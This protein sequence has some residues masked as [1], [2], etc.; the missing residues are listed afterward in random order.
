MSPL[1][2]IRATASL[3]E[4]A[5]RAIRA[6]I[7]T[8][9]IRSEEIYSAPALAAQLGVS[10]TPVREAMLDLVAQGLVE[11]IRN[12]GFRILP[13]TD[14]DLDQIHEL[15]MLIEV[16]TVRRLAG[17]IPKKDI[18]R[19]R[20]FAGESESAASAG[21]LVRFLE[22]DRQFHL[23]LLEFSGNRRLVDFIAQL[24]AQARLYGLRELVE[25]EALVATAQEHF[26]LLDSIERGDAAMAGDEMVKHLRHTRGAWAGRAEEARG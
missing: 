10:A 23:G 24:R 22:A 26:S 7:V 25:A 9:E 1:Q 15:R 5:L 4:E 17:Q 16:P 20:R 13:V 18:A 21:D 11:P 8:G 14:S 19:L 12:R 3:R 2:E 6:G